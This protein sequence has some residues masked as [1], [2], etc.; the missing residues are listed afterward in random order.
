MADEGKYIYGVIPANGEESFGQIGIEEGRQ[1]H[2]IIC[3]DIAAVVS[4]TSL[5]CC[6]PTRKNMSAHNRVLETVMKDHTILPA[7]FGL[8]ATDRERLQSL[9]AKYHPTLNNYLTMLD[10]RMEVGVKVFW[11][12]E[13]MLGTLEGRSH[14]LSRLQAEVNK[15][16]PAKAQV[17]LV[18]AGRLVKEQAEA[19]H[20]EYSDRFYTRLMKVA[21][22]GRRNYPVNITNLLNASFLVDVVKDKA[23]DAAIDELDAK[24]GEWALFRCV[25]PIPAYNF[26]NLEMYFN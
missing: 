6:D 15:A 7:R 23:F 20:T 13:R 8:V 16:P 4:D 24:Y 10:R 2:T 12:K 5:T 21:V 1:I 9:L 11:Q 19:W 25:K 3:K 22:D 17:L 26:V 18:E 14:K